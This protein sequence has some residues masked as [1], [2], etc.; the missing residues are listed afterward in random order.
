MLKSVSGWNIHLRTWQTVDYTTSKIFTAVKRRD[1]MT[2]RRLLRNG[3]ASPFERDED[4]NTLLHVSS[5]H[6]LPLYYM[7]KGDGENN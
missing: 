3:L 5:P 2:L 1:P 7:L 6:Y 4:G